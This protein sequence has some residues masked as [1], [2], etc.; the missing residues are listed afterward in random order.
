MDSYAHDVSL[1]LELYRQGDRGAMDRLIPLVYA[2]LRAIAGRYLGGERCDH[3]LQPTALVH[4][5]YMRMAAQSDVRWQNRAHFLGCAAQIM[6]NILVDYARKRRAEKRGSGE[7]MILLDEALVAGARREAN[8][9]ALDDALID[10]ARRNAEVA[11]VVE[12]KF[13]GGLSIEET[14]GVLRI[15]TARVERHWTFARAWLRR[16]LSHEEP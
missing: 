7:T 10:L 11:K 2:E 4:E 3:T 13:F 1:L 6:R 15:S 16:E 9:V 12:L 8:L 5:A 14:A